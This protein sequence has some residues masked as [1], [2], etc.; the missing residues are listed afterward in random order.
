MKIHKKINGTEQSSETESHI[1][2]QLMF[3]KGAKAI[4]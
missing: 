2:G 1:Y 3:N 4:Q